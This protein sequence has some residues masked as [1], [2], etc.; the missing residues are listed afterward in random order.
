M[1]KQNCKMMV[2][3]GTES[4]ELNRIFANKGNCGKVLGHLFITSSNSHFFNKTDLEQYLF[5]L[6]PLCLFSVVSKQSI[7]RDG[8]QQ[9]KICKQNPQKRC[10]AFRLHCN[11]DPGS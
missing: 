6:R 5:K 9:Q 4:N 11:T 7:R 10:S 8:P 3:N 2:A 1:I